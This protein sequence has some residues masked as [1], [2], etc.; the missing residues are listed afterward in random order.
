ME[1]MVDTRGSYVYT[2]TRPLAAGRQTWLFVHGA[3]MDHSVWVL[4]SRYFAYHGCN[5]LAVDLPG[6]GRSSG[7][8]LATIGDAAEWLAQLLDAAGID[9]AVVV[10]HSMGSLIALEFAARYPHRADALALLGSA[11]PMTVAESLLRAA[12]AN[13]TKA[14]D[15]IV[16]WGHSVRSAL[17]GNPLPGLWLVNESRRLLERAPAGVL[18]AD[19]TACNGYTGGVTSAAQV[20]CPARVVAGRR[21]LM[22][23]YRAAAALSKILPNSDYVVIADCGHMMMIEQPDA[24][25]DALI[26]LSRRI[27][28]GT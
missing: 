21:D 19:L 24:T 27:N 3:G 10:G 5:V 7:N 6:H 28:C 16:G 8:A 18:Y 17:G 9:S 25:L 22:T 14:I 11:T 20:S 13:D 1:L 4:Q 15:L 2:G 12:Q 23:P 26:G